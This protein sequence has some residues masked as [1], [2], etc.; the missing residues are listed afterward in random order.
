MVLNRRGVRVIF[1]LVCLAVALRVAMIAMF[2]T[3]SLTFLWYYSIVGRIDQFLIGMMAA[4]LWFRLRSEQRASVARFLPFSIILVL[5][6]LTV[7][8]QLGGYPAEG[9]WRVIWSTVEAVMWGAF[10]LTFIASGG[11]K[12]RWFGTPLTMVGE[13][14]FSIYLLHWPLLIEMKQQVTAIFLNSS[15]HYLFQSPLTA[16]LVITTFMLAPIIISVSFVTFRVIEKPFLKMRVQYLSQHSAASKLS[17][18]R[19]AT[20]DLAS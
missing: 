7:F 6:V 2:R 11:V 18:D 3:G 19:F 5:F 15:T 12:G 9:G 4:V 14:S 10:I 1:A 8:N 13:I 20:A 16:V 17:D